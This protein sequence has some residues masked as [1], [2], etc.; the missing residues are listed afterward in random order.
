[1]EKEVKIDWVQE[2]F[3]RIDELTDNLSVSKY[4]LLK[5]SFL[6]RLIEE[7]FKN[8]ATCEICKTHLPQ[9][10]KMIEEIP[11]LD[12]IDHRSPYEKQFNLIRSHFHK[13]HGFIQPYQFTTRW[14][15][16][17]V[18]VGGILSILWS[19]LKLG[20]IVMDALLLGIGLG[21]TFGYLW[22][23]FKEAK[24]RKQKKII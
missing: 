6:K 17:G 13:K 16:I 10:E 18:A 23:S 5:M 2:K 24:F 8:S 12:L 4:N 22:G 21:L 14:T 15:L 19:Y 7:S 11:H 3:Q 1:M 20:N 9:L